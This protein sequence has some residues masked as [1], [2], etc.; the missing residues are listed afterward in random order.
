MASLDGKLK[1][2]DEMFARLWRWLPWLT[3]FLFTLPAPVPFIILFLTSSSPESAA[4]YLLFSA[5]AL[6]A[7]AV[8]GLF[9]LVVLL[10]FKRRW[11]RRLRD[12]LAEDGI[13]A[14][15]VTWFTSELTSAE[16]QTLGE[17]QAH[18]PLLADAYRETLAS[19]LTAT[20]IIA[21]ASS[22]RLRV[23]RRITRARSIRG[24]DTQ[25]LLRD[26][27]ADHNQLENL[28][29]EANSRLA[30]SKAR[31]QTIEAV[32]SRTLNKKDT[33]MMLQRLAE[34]QSHIPLALELVKL[35]QEVLREA[36]TDLRSGLTGPISPDI[37]DTQRR[38]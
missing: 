23:E 4:V 10:L 34:S 12:R 9:A 2:K 36:E 1:N 22:E 30:E 31:L 32:A 7:G 37:G 13:T 35:Q 29:L 38:T 16:R 17:I 21:R 8:V 5:L 33:D 19:R 28:R 25:A 3:F 20:R 24:A 26:L 6:G 27:E 18:N 15:E 11:F 14:N